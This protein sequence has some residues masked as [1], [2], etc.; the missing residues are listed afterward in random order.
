MLTGRHLPDQQGRGTD[1]ARVDRDSRLAG[2]YGF[3]KAV[4]SGW[5]RRDLQVS[6]DAGNGLAK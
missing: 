5:A 2:I 4:S 1:I 6:I 3:V